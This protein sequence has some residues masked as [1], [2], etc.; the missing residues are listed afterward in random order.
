MHQALSD[1]RDKIG[2]AITPAGEGGGP[3]LGA[4]Q[5]VHLLAGVNDVAVGETGQGRQ[6]LI[7]GDRDHRLIEHGQTRFD[8][9]AGESCASLEDQGNGSDVGVSES[10]G[11]LKG[12]RC[13]GEHGVNLAGVGVLERGGEEKPPRSGQ[14]SLSRATRRSARLSHPA[15]APASP[16]RSRM[17]PSQPAQRAAAKGSPASR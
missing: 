12:L 6:E 1:V 8:L 11:D 2:L 7:I 17:V 14:S 15:A 13:V 16:L 3:L 9:P 5:V 10:F 4:A